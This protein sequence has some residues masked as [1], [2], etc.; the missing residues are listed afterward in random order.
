MDRAKKKRIHIIGAGPIGLVTANEL[1][2]YGH[3]VIVYEKNIISGGMCRTWEWGDFLVDTGPHIFHT[4]NPNLAKY[5]EEEFGDL[6]IKGDF[7]CQNVKGKDFTEYWDYP[8]SWESISK[9]P[10][11][12]KKNIIAELDNLNL[13]KRAKA[14]NYSDYIETFVGPTLKKMFFE[15]YPKKIWGLNTKEITHEWAPKRIEFRNKI[16]PF[17]H[18]QWN[19]VGKYG[20]GSIYKKIETSI[21]NKKGKINF[22][23]SLKKIN[24]HKNKI[25]SLVFENHEEVKIG[26]D[27]IVISSLPINFTSKLL[28]FESKLTFRGIR[29]VYLA[30]DVDQIIKGRNQWLYYGDDTIDFNRVTEPKKLS[31]F[32][33]PKNKTYLTAEITFSKNDEIDLIDEDELIQNV[34]NQ[35]EKVGLIEKSK[36]INGSDNKESFVY[37]LLYRGYQEDLAITKA[38]I[39][40]FDQL[41]SIG[42]GGEYNYADSQVIFEKA[43]DTANIISNIS[44]K[45]TQEIRMTNNSNL[46]KTVKIKETDIG[47]SNQCY[48]IAEIGINHNGNINLAKELIDEAKKIGVNAV[49]I[50]TFTAEKRLSKKVKDANYAEQVI[51]T[52]E[53]LFQTLDKVSLSFKD[54]E[55]LFDYARNSGVEIFSTPFDEQSVDYLESLNVNAYKIASMDLVNIPLIK[56]VSQTNKPVIL[57]TGMSTIGQIDEA[58]EAF[59]STGNN[60]LILLHCNSSYPSA[61]EE[62]NLNVI[63]SLKKYYDIPVGLSDHTIGLLASQIAITLGADVIERHFTMNRTFEGPD[64]ILSSEPR[65]MENLVRLTKDI[66]KIIGNTFKNIQ[67]NEYQTLN[68]QRKSIYAK[69]DIKEGEIIKSS[70]IEI[71]GPGGGLLPKY[72]E[73]VIG[74]KASKFIEKDTPI[75]W[76][77]I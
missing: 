29:S 20:T 58:V 3:D 60:N 55:I 44:S 1:L 7:W 62:M 9:Y 77:N 16:T 24:T 31:P 54:H 68:Q 33:S 14:T 10:L 66:P 72:L 11:D 75:N 4:P 52:E 67:P 45:Y 2:N 21:I 13:D 76:N 18:N 23:T 15:T 48:V 22:K 73:I 6:F 51:G 38:N 37:P 69:T 28:G 74:R 12:I 50:Q 40:K 53:T 26:K 43:F 5:W 59:K 65:E 17:Y 32:I 34:A 41:Y 27:E 57:S 35:I 8:I 71:K 30:Y 64:H 61:P 63:N 39:S 46:N 36:L 70:M 25:V 47:S 56:Y 49:K 19:A 42:T